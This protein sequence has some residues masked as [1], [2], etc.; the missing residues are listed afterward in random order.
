[1]GVKQGAA[2]SLMLALA[3]AVACAEKAPE[4]RLSR[5][6]L[7]DKVRGG[8][9]GQMI[10]VAYGGPTEFRSNGKILEGEIAWS[11]EMIESTL[12]QD[13]LYVEM[14]FAEVM[15]TVGLEATTE[16]YGEMFRDSEYN[17]W[18]AN[19]G[20]RRNLN[21]G[22]AAPL[23]GHPKYNIHANDIDFQIESDFIGLM[24]PG[25]PREANRYAD[26]VGRVMN[27]GDG[28]YGGI[29]VSGMYAAGFFESDPR[30]VVEAGVKSI[31]AESGY[32]QVIADVLAWHSEHPKDW[33]TTW[34]LLEEKWDQNDM[35]PAGALTPFNIDARLN[36]AYIALGLLYGGG[37]L[38]RTLEIST[39]SGQ[40]SDCNPSSAAGVLGVM[41]GYEALPDEF[42]SGIPAIGDERFSYTDYSFNEIVA[43][44]LKRAES[45]IRGAG[46]RVTDTEVVI[47]VQLPAAPPLE[48]WDADPPIQRL[49]IDDPAW[50]WTGEWTVETFE[51]PR[52]EWKL[53]QTTQA[54]AEVSLTFEGSGVAIVGG[55]TQEGGRA[56]VYLDGEKSD[57][58]LDAWIPERTH[59]NDYWHVTGLAPG[60]HAVRIVVRDDVDERST[61][62]VIQIQNAVVYGKA[63]R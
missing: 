59:D 2:A 18:H 58:V 19:A 26:R 48:Q 61:G 24:C 34:T 21:R 46:G 60:E 10:G 53:R 4:R 51:R 8:W 3:G 37:D 13:D 35:C 45:V 11:P 63:A 40:D 9:A 55:M 14:T 27:Y 39:R 20:A 16:Q 33:R 36:G 30:R 62:R 25:L 22:I 56:D 5:T 54:G 29:F 49:E 6:M 31:P 41:L 42:K 47:P 1:M 32:A 23:S 38:A 17:L 52:G 15:D 44:T 12:R 7:E 57:N 43:S 28:L 50:E